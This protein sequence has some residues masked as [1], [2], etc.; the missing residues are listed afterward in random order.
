[1]IE[2]LLSG[3]FWRLRGIMG[4]P[5]TALFALIQAWTLWSAFGAWSLLFSLWIIAGEPTGWKPKHILDRGDWIEAATDGLRIGGIGAI[6]VPLSTWLHR[7]FGEPPFPNNPKP[8]YRPSWL[9]FQSWLIPAWTD[10]KPK[11]VLYWSGAFN[12][13]YF[14][15]IFSLVL[16]LIVVMTN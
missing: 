6:A 7:R 9:P 13:A 4:W 16:Q 8:F 12:E 3:L 14:G 2:V 10:K 15:L 1:M 11:H 5:F